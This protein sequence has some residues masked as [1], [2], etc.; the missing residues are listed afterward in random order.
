MIPQK[1]SPQFDSYALETSAAGKLVTLSSDGNG[2]THRA[3]DTRSDQHV[4]VRVFSE[5]LLADDSVQQEFVDHAKLLIELDHPS[6]T[7]II[8]TGQHA[9]QFFYVLE[10]P[11]GHTVE[12]SIE[13][14]GPFEVP[15]AL[16]LHLQLSEALLAVRT[17]PGLLSRVRPRS[18]M[19]TEDGE[20]A[21]IHLLAQNLVAPSKEE[22]QPE[23]LAPEILAGHQDTAQASLYSI[24]AT[25]Y[26][27]LTGKPPYLTGLPVEDLLEI[28]SKRLPD[29]AML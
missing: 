21:Q 29:L 15:Y 28:K 26:Y 10:D 14:S 23:F 19:V 9:D 18:L 11:G 27:M 17:K 24:G 20:A 2:T 6:I 8:D 5:R 22:E 4:I 1:L 16:K 7:R 12:E 25:L 3:R 13:A